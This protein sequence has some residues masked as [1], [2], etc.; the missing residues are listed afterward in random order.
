MGFG[1][2]GLGFGGSCCALAGLKIEYEY[3]HEYGH[4]YEREYGREYGHEY[5]YEYEKE[6]EIEIE[7]EIETNK[8]RKKAGINPALRFRGVRGLCWRRL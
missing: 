7:I 6:K 3:G 2:W 5:E 8:S 4:E 1:V